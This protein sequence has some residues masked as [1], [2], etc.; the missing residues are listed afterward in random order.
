MWVKL[1]QYGVKLPHK[2]L[3]MTSCGYVSDRRQGASGVVGMSLFGLPAGVY[4]PFWLMLRCYKTTD[5]G[6]AAIDD[7]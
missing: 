3:K 6:A 7:K 2:G 1:L 5:L 4:D